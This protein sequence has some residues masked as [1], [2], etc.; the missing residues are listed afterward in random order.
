MQEKQEIRN[1]TPRDIIVN[2]T[3][4]IFRDEMLKANNEHPIVY[5][6]KR[7]VVLKEYPTETLN[8][9]RKYLFLKKNIQGNTTKRSPKPQRRV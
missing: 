6:G 9:R 4:K 2:F 3:K 8:R 5:K 1:K 7:I